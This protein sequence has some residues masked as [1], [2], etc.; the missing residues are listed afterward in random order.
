MGWDM[1][2]LNFP[3]GLS[4]RHPWHSA[5]KPHCRARYFS[6]AQNYFQTTSLINFVFHP[7]KSQMS[8][9]PIIN[10]FL[11]GSTVAVT[12]SV[13]LYAAT[14]Y[15]SVSQ[16]KGN[17]ISATLDIPKSFEDSYTSRELVNPRRHKFITDSR[18]ITFVLPAKNGEKESALK[19][20]AV[21]ASA[22]RGFFSGWVFTP[23]RI[24]LTLLRLSVGPFP[25]M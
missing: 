9:R 25:S 24:A 13:G 7:L 4:R 16:V 21:L 5:Y 12:A 10:R 20:E 3:M 6:S 23:E 22:V 2:K 11:I 19:D 17:Q 15:R 18:S 14:V 8:F 1:F